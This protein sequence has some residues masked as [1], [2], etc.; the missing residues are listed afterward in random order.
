MHDLYNDEHLHHFNIENL[1][2]LLNK[3]GFDVIKYR[4]N[5]RN[6]WDLIDILFKVKDSQIPPALTFQD[7][8][9][10]QDFLS[11]F[12]EKRSNDQSRLKDIIASEASIGIY[13]GGWHTEVCLPA[14]YEFSFEKVKSIFDADERKQGNK[15]FGIE[16]AAPKK[17]II[18][19]L[20]MIIISSINLNQ[21]I[22]DF[23]VGMGISRK[24]I[25]SIY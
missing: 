1:S 2:N 6:D 9:A 17:D 4:T 15:L 16:V 23:L 13:G 7:Q 25:V 19:T 21:D 5:R 12:N 14:Y 3:N 22:I 18:D 11:Q 20:D 8:I 24:R 10:P